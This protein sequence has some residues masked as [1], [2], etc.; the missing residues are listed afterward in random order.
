MQCGCKAS[1]NDDGHIPLSALDLRN[2]ST[3]ET[4]LESKFLL[5][6][7]QRF[8]RS[9]HVRG[10][11]PHNCRFIHHRGQIEENVD[12]WSTDYES[13]FRLPYCRR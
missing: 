7:V 6:Q 12:Y 3:I 13:H 10:D 9:S 1:K 2:V 4:C 5:R 11:Y 8:S